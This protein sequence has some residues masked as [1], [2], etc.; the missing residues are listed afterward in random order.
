[1]FFAV[2]CLLPSFSIINVEYRNP[3]F[4]PAAF[5]ELVIPLWKFIPVV[6][7]VAASQTRVGLYIRPPSFPRPL[8]PF[9]PFLLLPNPLR[10]VEVTCAPITHLSKSSQ[11]FPGAFDRWA[12]QAHSQRAY[13]I[14]FLPKAPRFG[15]RESQR[16]IPTFCRYHL[17]RIATVSLS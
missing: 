5:R 14:Y 9:P 4:Y 6:V 16:S 12:L 11:T 10:E 1:M 17:Y 15:L 7:D 3:F 2:Y 8:R 13:F